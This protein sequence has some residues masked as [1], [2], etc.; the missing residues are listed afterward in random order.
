MK[1]NDLTFI[2]ATLVLLAPFFACETVYQGY[3]AFNATHPYITAFL[4]FAI[5][6]TAGEAIGLSIKTG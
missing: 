5:L 4:K 1:K 2:A 6:A 3:T